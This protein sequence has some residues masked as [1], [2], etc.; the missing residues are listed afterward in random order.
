HHLEL[1]VRILVG[2]TLGRSSVTSTVTCKA[3]RARDRRGQRQSRAAHRRGPRHRYAAFHG[4]GGH[5]PPVVGLTASGPPPTCSPSA[6]SAGSCSRVVTRR[7][8]TLSYSARAGAFP[9]RH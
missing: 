7:G 2:S 3:R 6:S 1:L 8:S 9:P 5:R 4:A